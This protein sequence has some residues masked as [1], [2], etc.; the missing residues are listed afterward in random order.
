MVLEM[1]T[2]PSVAGTEYSFF[3]YDFARKTWNDKE[4]AMTNKP[5]SMHLDHGFD[6]EKWRREDYVNK[7]LRAT[8]HVTEWNKEWSRDEYSTLPEMPFKV[9]RLHFYNR[10]EGTTG[11]KPQIL[12]LTVGTWV[13]VVSKK[14]PACKTTIN[15]FQSAILPASFGDF[16]VINPDGGHSTVVVFSWK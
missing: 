2:C 1:D 4:Q 13:E 15:R 5:M 10:S 16:E 14:N 9:E 6:N 12:T 3:E 11:G 7:K 8:K